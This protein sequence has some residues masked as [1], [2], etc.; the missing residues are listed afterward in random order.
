[1]LRTLFVLAILIPGVIAAV[2]SRFAALQLYLWFAF[3]R[4]QEWMWWDVSAWRPS[5]L[6][7]LLLVI[8]CLL[9]GVLPNVSHPISLGALAFLFVSCVSQL[10]SI[11]PDHSSYWLE[12]LIRLLLVCLLA[13]SLISDTKRFRLTLIVIGASFGFHSAK[14]GLASLL[15]GGLR[16]G[17][18]L[19]GA[20]V[21]NNGYAVGMAMLIPLLLLTAQTATNRWVRA[22][23]LAAVPLTALAVV[24][25]FSRGG[26]LA[27]VAA[28]VTLAL[29][30][31]RRAWALAVIV[32][33]AIPIGWF[34]ATHDAYVTRVETIQTYSDIGETS[35][36]SRLHFWRVAV[37][38]AADRP[39]G[40]GL[41][42]YERAYDR[43]D[44]LFGTFG[45]R[46]SV[47][48]SH[49]QVL[50]ETGFLGAAI[51]GALLAY[52]YLCAFRIRR[53]GSNPRIPD[54]DARLF[55]ASGNAF[56]A[57]MTAFVVGGSFIAIALNDLT[58]ILLACIASIDRISA[59]RIS[60]VA[61][62]TALA[63]AAMPP[64]REW[65]M[66]PASDTAVW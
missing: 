5:L 66:Q 57:S 30:E 18:G 52:G 49:F 60:E 41:F 27:L 13:I 31:R 35:A 59:Q 9:T 17:A 23:F 63:S 62:E 25:T 36:L 1:M 3:F 34:M 6:L 58:W 4:P 44:F 48:S 15:G 50:A 10:N 24:S 28:G 16:F 56:I 47:H 53:R 14:A 2:W 65:A 33:L 37:D 64:E 26:L 32:S 51:Y 8:P 29:L 43:Y 11:A 46:R 45:Y 54:P 19:A 40:V 7:G 20:F 22:G 12:Y 61:T 42:N 39:L 21:D 38:M 55:I